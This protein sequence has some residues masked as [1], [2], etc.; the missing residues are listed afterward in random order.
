MT[1]NCSVGEWDSSVKMVKIVKEKGKMLQSCGRTLKHSL[2]IYAEEAVLL[3]DA[4]GIIVALDNNMLSLGDTFNLLMEAKVPM[5]SYLAYSQLRQ[6]GYIVRRHHLL[7][8][9]DGM[10]NIPLPSIPG[11]T[12]MDSYCLYSI[13][14]LAP[15][16]LLLTKYMSIHI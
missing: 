8:C 6:M 3:S 14:N 13:D 12:M 7:D 15:S 9:V 5:C 1:K 10:S 4:G 16:H 2:Y 11:E